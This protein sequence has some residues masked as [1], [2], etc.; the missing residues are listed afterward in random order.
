MSAEVL[1]YCNVC[2]CVALLHCR[3]AVRQM[4]HDSDGI[5]SDI[6][7]AISTGVISLVRSVHKSSPLPTK[8]EDGYTLII[9]LH[10]RTVGVT[11]IA[12]SLSVSRA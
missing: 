9:V 5:Q 8:Y 12:M 3:L 7:K 10:A 2:L 6:V 4:V 11:S 1:N